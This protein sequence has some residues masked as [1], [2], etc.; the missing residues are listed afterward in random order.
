MP[1]ILEDRAFEAK[2]AFEQSR[3]PIPWSLTGEGIAE[4]T[5]L[6]QTYASSGKEQLVEPLGEHACLVC[7]TVS[8][9]VFTSGPL[10]LNETCTQYGK[11]RDS[12]DWLD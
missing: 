12:D 1:K 6:V 10:C 5:A 11:V 4:M 8:P 3:Q 2:E 7:S 9:I